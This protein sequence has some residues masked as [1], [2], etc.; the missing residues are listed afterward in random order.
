MHSS[1]VAS[2]GTSLAAHRA[3]LKPTLRVLSAL[4]LTAGLA[5]AAFAQQ[6]MG[7]QDQRSQWGM[8]S[9]TAT[10][11][12]TGGTDSGASG[13]TG[14][15]GGEQSQRPVIRS[16]NSPS[17]QGNG[18][19][20]GNGPGNAN[21]NG[22]LP[23]ARTEVEVP[24]TPNEFQVFVQESI[25]QPLPIYGSDFFLNGASAAGGGSPFAPIQNIPV[26]GDYA[27]GPGDELLIRGWGAV[28]IDVRATVDRNGQIS[29][30][31]IGTI[32]LAG[33]KAS[34]AEDVVHAAIGRVFKDFELS[35]TLGQLRSITVYL[36]GQS[37]RPGAYNLSSVSTLVSALFASGGPNPNGSLRHVQ[38]KRGGRVVTEL[39][40]YAFLARGDKSG[41]FKLLDGDVIFIPPAK[42]YVALTGKVTSP[43]IYELKGPEE[44]IGDLLSV[45]GGMP[46]VADPRRAFLERITPG[47]QQPRTVEE[48]ALDAQGL[49]KT[50][51]AGDVLTVL[52]MNSEFSNAV[53]L[54]GNVNQPVR[55]PFREGMRISDLIPNAAAL[56]NRTSVRR[57]NE[58][59]LTPSQRLQA[60]RLRSANGAVRGT[61]AVRQRDDEEVRESSYTLASRI[62][63]LTEQVNM[64]YAVI[65][66][67]NRSDLSVTLIPFNLGNVL[68]NQG[69]TDNLPLQPGDIVTVFSV[70]DVRVPIAKRSVY[71][72]IEGEV[73]KP[74]VYQMM[75]GDSLQSLVDRAGGLTPDAYLFGASFYR[76]DVRKNQQEN[77][78]KLVRRLEAESNSSLSQTLQSQGAAAD[79]SSSAVQLRLQA[80]QLAQKQALERLR[81]VKAT[82]R[83]AL[84][85][86]IDNNNVVARLPAMKME[87]GDRLVV[88]NRPDY[89]YIFGSVNTESALVYRTNA[90]VSDYLLQAGLSRGSDRDN[91]IL[92]RA[93]G[94]AQ[95]NT[96]SW[97]NNV[98]SATVMPGDTIILPEKLDQETTWSAVVR[99]AKDFSQIF[100]QLG[101]GAAAIQVLRKN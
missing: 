41:D 51:R 84:G 49:Q 25:G 8:S 80:A 52:T 7:T 78:E 39:D 44:S 18:N 23:A 57:Q 48:F 96:S 1:P 20:N 4:M 71:V 86:P 42:D 76:E 9:Q 74:G 27:L 62:G 64:D 69:S 2:Y 100:Y 56:L 87:N 85:L 30:P 60:E 13:T 12:T 63:Q 95:T 68:N 31:R 47:K 36:V 50:V 32:N 83:I 77:L 92:L 67:V 53:T 21:G 37:H 14:M 3:T 75:Q 38:L 88:P 55:Q 72:L 28:D 90:S 15:G 29:I 26:T 17:G 98:L 65:E 101:L 46:V 70:N 40:L 97:S 10:Q 16:G 43:A 24:S 54:R 59:L 11:G 99:N 19:A 91:V 22:N 58:V 5:S 34:Q 73:G 93:D 35:V 66:R 61:S 79:A 6:G 81:T 89:V 82:G 45:A 33:V 94:S